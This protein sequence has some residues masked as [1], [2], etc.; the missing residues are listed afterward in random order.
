MPQI[1][2]SQAG[3]YLIYLAQQD[4]RLRWPWWLSIQQDTAK[5]IYKY[6]ILYVDRI[7]IVA[8]RQGLT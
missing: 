1:N 5:L 6:Q 7:T 4:E 3:H 8:W 2:S